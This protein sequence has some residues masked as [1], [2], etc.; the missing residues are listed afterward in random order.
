MRRRLGSGNPTLVEEALKDYQQA[1]ADTRWGP[2]NSYR[3][4]DAEVREAARRFLR[5]GEY[6]WAAL[7]VMWHLADADDAGLLAD[8]LERAEDPGVRWEALHAAGAA[9]GAGVGP[10]ARLLRVV[11]AVALDEG[12]DTD[13]REIALRAL[14]ELDVPEV[15]EVALR[16]CGSGE[17][18]VQVCAA[19]YLS[20]PERV[21]V[22]R[23]RVRRLVESWPEDVGFWGEQVREALALGGDG[24]GVG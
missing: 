20:A 23:E 10:D 24:S 12:G 15:V 5:R 17:L 11:S 14:S 4:L 7:A 2:S 18:A 1:Q 19:G 16:A 8:V 3:G 13:V 6:R 9:L 22:H 21:G